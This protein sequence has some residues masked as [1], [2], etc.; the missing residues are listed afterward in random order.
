MTDHCSKLALTAEGKLQIDSLEL[1]GPVKVVILRMVRGHQYYATATSGSLD[2]D[3][4]FDSPDEYDET[5]RKL[6]WNRRLIMLPAECL[7]SVKSVSDSKYLVFDMPSNSEED[8]AFFE[9]IVPRTLAPEFYFA[10]AAI[11]PE[12]IKTN[13][14]CVRYHPIMPIRSSAIR[15]AV[16]ARREDSLRFVRPNEG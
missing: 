9:H 14:Y 10:I 6:V 16:I 12:E 5:N 7:K 13:D 11:E 15:E 3:E 4:M 8:Y 1:D 2:C